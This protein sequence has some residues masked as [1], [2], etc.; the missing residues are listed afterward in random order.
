MMEEVVDGSEEE[1]AFEGEC[2][3][4]VERVEDEEGAFQ[5]DKRVEQEVWDSRIEEL[6]SDSEVVVGAHSSSLG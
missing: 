1:G 6:D 4:G 2:C 3:E 5:E